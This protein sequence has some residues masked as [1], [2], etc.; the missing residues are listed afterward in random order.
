M[1]KI[2]FISA[3]LMLGG[4][5]QAQEVT[6]KAENFNNTLSPFKVS[7][8]AMFYRSI[9]QPAFGGTVEGVIANR[10][11]YHGTF[12]Y[13]PWNN[14]AIQ[15]EHMN[16]AGDKFK[17]EKYFE[18][19]ADL[20]LFSWTKEGK[21]K[22]KVTTSNDG[23][24]ERYFIARTDIRKTFAVRGGVVN[25]NLVRYY[26][27]EDLTG[28][29][30]GKEGEMAFRNFTMIGGYAGVAFRKIKKARITSGGW[31]Y[32]KNHQRIFYMDVMTAGGVGNAINYQNT[33]YKPD[34]KIDA[35]GYR[36]GFQWDQQGT[37][38]T[39]EFGKQPSPT[40]PKDLPMAKYYNYMTLG[41]SFT[42]FGGDKRYG[43]KEKKS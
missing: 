7:L 32:Y 31:I 22:F 15:H 34:S 14:F 43:M 40:S 3:F 38:T 29:V 26:N 1:K 18:A 16:D 5:L 9:L 21:G 36:M 11:A 13:S 6:Y 41:F 20:F 27:Y 12:L 39:W 42:L 17:K 30:G 33:E 24:T 35:L 37:I 10:V 4:T 23:V 28:T 2:I 19:G 25:Y 8:S